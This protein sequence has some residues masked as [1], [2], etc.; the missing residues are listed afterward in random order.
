MANTPR[1]C[2]RPRNPTIT[3]NA[4]FSFTISTSNKLTWEVSEGVGVLGGTVEGADVAG[5]LFE[6]SDIYNE[7]YI[8]IFKYLYPMEG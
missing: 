5:R 8:I 2:A 1:F 3:F 4:A 7:I 6:E